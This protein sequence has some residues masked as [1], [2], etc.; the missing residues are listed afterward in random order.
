MTLVQNIAPF[1][2]LHPG[3]LAALRC[4]DGA[5]LRPG[6]RPA[7]ENGA[8]A[9]F[10]GALQAR[11]AADGLAVLRGFE[12]AA[13]AADA[14]GL[15]WLAALA[16][17]QAARHAAECDL[18]SARDHYR[19]QSLEHYRQCEARGRFHAPQDT[20]C[21]GDADGAGRLCSPKALALSIAHEVNQPMAALA[22]HMGAACRW[23]RRAEP[24]VARALDSL[25]LAET[26][27][28]Q[29]GAIVRGMQ[30]LAGG[31]ALEVARVAV[32]GAIGEVLLALRRT[33]QAHGI[34]LEQAL[35]LDALCIEANGV[36]LQQVVTNL[37]VNA[38]EVHARH[39]SAGPRFIRITSRRHGANEI[40]IAVTDNGPGIP[41]S[42]RAAIFTS[43]FSTKPARTG[44]GA[45]MGLS[46]CLS[47]VRAHGGRIWCE[48]AE[49]HGACFRLR[50]PLD[51]SG[52]TA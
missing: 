11:G 24:D 19:R 12:Q 44:H 10:A 5:I 32:D 16:Y 43:L 30:R 49:P 50:L 52:R 51:A 48:P 37:I 15:H 22:L 7:R 25:A 3:A 36:Q 39:G 28:R 45:G 13:A 4:H 23:L 35:G 27:S 41:P 2:H 46:I 1:K 9:A 40:E 6:Q 42:Q 47:I 20:A 34:V 33:W 38:V 14:D 29:A 26:A 18:V 31:D 21:G 17:E 8:L